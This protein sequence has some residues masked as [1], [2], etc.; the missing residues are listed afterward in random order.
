MRRCAHCDGAVE[1]GPLAE[2]PACSFGCAMDAGIVPVG[3][4]VRLDD[5]AAEWVVEEGWSGRK[6]RGA[7][8]APVRSLGLR[9]R[10][11]R[12]KEVAPVAVREVLGWAPELE[13][14]TGGVHAT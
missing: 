6:P 11:G 8:F 4:V 5:S 12:R 9:A 2:L 1:V 3:L 7:R 13:L 10:N 14:E